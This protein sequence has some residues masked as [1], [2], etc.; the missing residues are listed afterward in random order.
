MNSRQDPVRIRLTRTGLV[1]GNVLRRATNVARERL[2]QFQVYC[3]WDRTAVSSKACHATIHR[4]L[5]KEVATEKTVGTKSVI[6]A[7]RYAT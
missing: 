5:Q 7:A 3:S 1:M 4:T 6:L 2:I